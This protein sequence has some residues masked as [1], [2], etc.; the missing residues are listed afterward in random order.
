MNNYLT[1]RIYGE[2]L[3]DR[4]MV[5]NHLTPRIYGG[6]PS[7]SKGRT[8]GQKLVTANHK[9]QASMYYILVN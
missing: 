9:I 1:P 8:L 2:Q 3:S 6:Q 7:D 4:Y 5:N